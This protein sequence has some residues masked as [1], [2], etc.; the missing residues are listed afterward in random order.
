MLY[1]LCCL[2]ILTQDYSS[3]TSHRRHACGTVIVS[4][5]NHR[6]G[7]SLRWCNC[8]TSDQHSPSPRRGQAGWSSKNIGEA[9]WP[10]DRIQ[11]RETSRYNSGCIDTPL[12]NLQWFGLPR[13][14]SWS[15]EPKLSITNLMMH[16]RTSQGVRPGIFGSQWSNCN[17][18][19]HIDW[20]LYNPV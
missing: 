13:T 15:S 18:W 7:C 8:F 4:S 17:H 12:W 14:L 11:H 9:Y 10:T 3:R 1:R 5:V 19:V 6:R 20:G 16:Y 2:F